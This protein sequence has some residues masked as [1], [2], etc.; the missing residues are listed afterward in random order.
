VIKTIL[1]YQIEPGVS[2][3]D[4]EDWLFNVHVPDILA[5]PFVDKLVFSKVLRPVPFTSGGT[6]VHQALS[7]YRIAEM[8]FASEDA[9][10]NYLQWFADH[11]VPADRSPAGRTAF[12]FY[13]VTSTRE[14]G[15]GTADGSAGEPAAS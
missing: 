9:Y 3:A 10:K 15:R 7:L 13:V 8:H 14:F 2:E 12:K 5:N 11:P 6:P 1:G 4:Y